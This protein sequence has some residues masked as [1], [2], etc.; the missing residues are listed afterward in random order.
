[1][2]PFLYFLDLKATEYIHR[3]FGKKTTN[4][5]YFLYEFEHLQWKWIGVHVSFPD[6]DK[7]FWA[8]T[9]SKC[10]SYELLLAVG[11]MLSTCISENLVSEGKN[12]KVTLW[13]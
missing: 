2:P 5:K 11:S 1:M 6:F 12:V 4:F 13:P 9:P 10:T 8:E 7:S 3:I